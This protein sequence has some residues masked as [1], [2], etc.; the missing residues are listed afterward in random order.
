MAVRL[1]RGA[2]R[3]KPARRCLSVACGGVTIVL[4][5]LPG[6]RLSIIR[7]PLESTDISLVNA[8]A[9]RLRPGKG[10]S[11]M[12]GGFRRAGS[13]ATLVGTLIYLTASSLAF[14][15]LWPLGGEVA[16]SFGLGPGGTALVLSLP[17]LASALFRVAAG[18][19]L[20]RFSARA[21][22]AGAQLVVIL[23]LGALC[24]T[25]LDT[26]TA[27]VLVAVVLGLAG[28]SVAIARPLI[29]DWYPVRHQRAAL[30]I[31]A[32]GDAG[33]AIAILAAPVLA[34]AVG[35]RAAI[36]LVL[37]PLVLGFLLYVILARSPRAGPTRIE[38]AAEL[39]SFAGADAWWFMCFYGVT[40]GGFLGLAAALPLYFS[41]V[42][43][44]GPVQ[45]GSYTALCVLVGV[46]ARPLGALMADRM[47]GI[48]SLSFMYV[49]I[50]MTLLIVANG[51]PLAGQALAMFILA[52]LASGTGNG[53]IFHLVPQRFRVN[54]SMATCLIGA[55][56]ALGACLFMIALGLSQQLT[57]SYAAG[58]LLF[59]ALAVVA[60]S[61]LTAVKRRWR[62]TWAAAIRARP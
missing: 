38:P 60:L 2:A 34:V 18:L 42:Y 1:G 54:V 62:T 49:I 17:F 16:L 47:G 41:T 21:I 28:A 7:I 45:A 59:A 24:L 43:G 8:S 29:A 4:I 11:G 44:V 35:W 19:A 15:I 36:A 48:K 55:A 5:A 52:M 13:P 53:A 61:G 6:A 37:V 20:A 51:L 39:A 27:I 22:G 14:A 10:R 40:L 12:T 50:I 25:G 33:L 3:I 57:G 58:F 30:A 32:G 56:G 9:H 23:A 31:L 46:A 26:L